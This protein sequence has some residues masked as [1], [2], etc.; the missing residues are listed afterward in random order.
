MAVE[1]AA[2]KAAKKNATKLVDELDIIGAMARRARRKL[3]RGG[4]DFCNA[5]LQDPDSHSGTS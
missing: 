5:G 3:H 2:K 4:I 1:E